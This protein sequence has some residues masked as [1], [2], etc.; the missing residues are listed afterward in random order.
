[1][2]LRNV[3]RLL[4][5]S[6]VASARQSLGPRP[7]RS[8]LNY[9]TLISHLSLGVRLPLRRLIFFTPSSLLWREPTPTPGLSGS[10]ASGVTPTDPGAQPNSSTG[11]DV[12]LHEARP[13]STL[14]PWKEA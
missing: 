9:E 1:M 6:L 5:S 4:S 3:P 8:G 10:T 7:L 13:V 11:R 12:L 14:G 2:G